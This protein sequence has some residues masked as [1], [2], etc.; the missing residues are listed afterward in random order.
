MYSYS[1]NIFQP[2]LTP[3]QLRFP[4]SRFPVVRIFYNWRPTATFSN[5]LCTA[6]TACWHTPVKESVSR[7]ACRALTGCYSVWS[8]WSTLHICVLTKLR[9]IEWLS[10]I[11]L[12]RH[13]LSYS[14]YFSHKAKQAK[15]NNSL[16]FTSLVQ[17]F[18]WRY[19]LDRGWN[20]WNPNAK[21]SDRSAVSSAIPSSTNNAD[22][23][24]HWFQ[25]IHLGVAYPLWYRKSWAKLIVS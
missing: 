19:H 2:D 8:W 9:Y 18:H 17:D 13:K 12:K 21:L 6:Q 7:L 4:K 11:K 10:R 25:T 1:S 3:E 24:I 22:F 20:V 5:V 14:R 15:N 23:Q 16:S